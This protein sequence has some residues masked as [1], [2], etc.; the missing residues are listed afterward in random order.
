MLQEWVFAKKRLF[1]WKVV[2]IAQWLKGEFRQLNS[3]ICASIRSNI[4]KST[5]SCLHPKTGYR[6]LM[7]LLIK[8]V[9]RAERWFSLNEWAVTLSLLFI[10]VIA[11]KFQH[12]Q[13]VEWTTL[14]TSSVILLQ[15]IKLHMY[16][17]KRAT[18]SLQISFIQNSSWQK[19]WIQNMA[20]ITT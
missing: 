2:I 20:E 15:S 6:L 16:M 7:S 14:D 19:C 11:F 5:F 10:L 8:S 17:D 4:R 1:S 13:A 12:S 9:R 18:M 3:A